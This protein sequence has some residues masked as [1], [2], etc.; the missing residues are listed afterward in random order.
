MREGGRTSVG[1]MST[2][3]F[4]K[5]PLFA[6]F[7]FHRADAPELKALDRWFQEGILRARSLGGWERDFPRMN[8]YGFYRSGGGS[9]EGLVGLMVPGRDAGGRMF[10]FTVFEP[11]DRGSAASF[12]PLLPLR[13]GGF[14]DR[15]RV[16]AS[17]S[18]EH[19]DVGALLGEIDRL[20]DLERPGWAET[21]AR[22]RNLLASTSLQDFWGGVLRPEVDHGDPVAVVQGLAEVL[23]PFRGSDPGR[24]AYALALPSAAAREEEG[25]LAAAVWLDL[26]GTCLGDGLTGRPFTCFW[27]LDD[28][29]P[30][31]LFLFFGELFPGAFRS[32]ADPK[33]DEETVYDLGNIGDSMIGKLRANAAAGLLR[34]LEEADG[35]LAEFL[36][37]WRET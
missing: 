8:A 34:L 27:S 10:P 1:M 9:A 30:A 17:S 22:Y 35:T 11:L 19:P 23:L 14:L 3:C 15:A 28:G 37:K 7:I 2:G 5:L 29:R 32:L 12:L 24:L 6:D 31:R 25:R 13:Y 21:G 20:A 16:L 18:Q 4:G 36:A 26:V 33:A